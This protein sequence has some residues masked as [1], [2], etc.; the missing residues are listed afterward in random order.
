MP[1]WV[2]FISMLSVATNI[3]KFFEFEVTQSSSLSKHSHP[4]RRSFYCSLTLC[5]QRE[6][7]INR[8][9]R[10]SNVQC[11]TRKQDKKTKYCVY[12][13]AN[14]AFIL[15]ILLIKSGLSEWFDWLGWSM[16]SRWSKCSRCSTGCL[17]KT[18]LAVVL[19][20]LASYHI[21]NFKCY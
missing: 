19:F 7:P 12:N 8:V 17:K 16:W 11:K 14:S 13:N 15:I 4:A 5:I 21:G 20:K 3:P 1:T 6:Y 9:R 18:S 10:C 2:V